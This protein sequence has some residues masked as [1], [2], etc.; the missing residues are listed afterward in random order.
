MKISIMQPTYLPWSGY[1]SMIKNA[2]IFV[3]LDD[4]QFDKRSWQQRNRILLNKKE[5]FLTVPV[6]SKKKLNQKINEVKINDSE[7]WS[8][9][10][11]MKIYHAYG[12]SRFFKEFIERLEKAYNRN[13]INLIDLNIF[14]IDQ[15][16]SYLEIKT[17]II[18]SSS[19]SNEFIKEKKL[20]EIC[21]KLDATEYIAPQGSKEYIDNGKVFLESNINFS[22]YN[23][24]VKEYDQF[25][26][27]KFIPYLSIIDLIFNNGSKSKEY[28]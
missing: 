11:F 17:K 2:D 22:Y 18:L 24:N 4:V 6:I 1:F 8:K 10:H 13:F 9:N 27:K 16:C 21:K 14:L 5:T 25:N 3:F 12:K 15:I 20:L 23:F 26:S 19:I 7:D 28:I